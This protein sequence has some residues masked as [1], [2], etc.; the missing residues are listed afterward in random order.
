MDLKTCTFKTLKK[1]RKPGENFLKTFGNPELMKIFKF[2]ISQK[3]FQV[4]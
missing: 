1:F 4:L 2:E 3:L